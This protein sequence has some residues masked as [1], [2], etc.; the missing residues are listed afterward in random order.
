MSD[1]LPQD[2][3]FSTGDVFPGGDETRRERRDIR[4]T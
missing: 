3:H 1:P 2:T 4:S